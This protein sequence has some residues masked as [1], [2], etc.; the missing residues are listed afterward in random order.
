M[1]PEELKQLLRV[2]PFVPLR[3]FLTDGKSYDI[4]HPDQVIV[5][6]ARVDI[7]VNPNPYGVV[8]RT[9]FVS[10]LHIVRLEPIAEMTA[11]SN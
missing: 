7:G 4:R 8:E 5:E 3:M 11:E 2:H 6:R 1:R 9:E 10:L